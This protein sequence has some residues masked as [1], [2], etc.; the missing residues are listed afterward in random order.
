MNTLLNF[1]K[2]FQYGKRLRPD[3]DWFALVAV[4]AALLV[5]SVVWNLWLFD[6]VK[7]GEV[8]RGAS[9]PL[10]TLTANERSISVIQESF[11]TRTAEESQYETGGSTFVDP[12]QE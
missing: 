4:G 11:T 5:I 1:F 10:S 2:K 6:E 9:A 8:L 7:S 3:Q 12:S